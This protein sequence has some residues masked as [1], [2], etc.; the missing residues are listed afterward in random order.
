MKRGE[1]LSWSLKGVKVKVHIT[2]HKSR[3][4]FVDPTIRLLELM[5]LKIKVNAIVIC[6]NDHN[7]I[8]KENNA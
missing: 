1:I 5:L 2:E 3:Q 7:L 4:C 8:S 6:Y